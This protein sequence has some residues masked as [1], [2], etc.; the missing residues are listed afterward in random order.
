MSEKMSAEMSANILAT[1]LL[2]CFQPVG[3]LLMWFSSFWCDVFLV[4]F[5]SISCERVFWRKFL[6]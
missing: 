4:I 2:L 5:S 1:L 6:V 3:V